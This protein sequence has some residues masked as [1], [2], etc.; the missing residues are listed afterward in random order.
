MSRGWLY[1]LTAAL[2][3]FILGGALFLNFRQGSGP[4]RRTVFG[5]DQVDMC[6]DVQAA[7]QAEKFDALDRMGRE[8][9]TL[10]DRFVG[11]R[12]KLSGFYDFTGMDGCASSFCEAR[13]VQP[14]NIRKL[15]NWLNR[16]PRNPI[17]K[18]AMALNWYFYAWASRSCAD[19]ADIS[20]DQWQGYF[21]RL[22]IARSYLSNIDPRES[23]QYYVLMIEILCESGGPRERLDALYQ[24][25]HSAFPDFYDLTAIYGWSL[26]RSWFGSA[27]DVAWLADT[28]LTDPGGDSGQVS[29]SFIAAQAA[30]VLSTQRYFPETGLSWEKIKRAFATRKQLYGLNVHDWNAYAYIAYAAGDREVAREAYAQFGDNWDPTV[31]EDQSFYFNK[32]LPW[33]KGQ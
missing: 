30:R 28:L 25:G 3:I 2:C 6:R 32:V 27:G 29:Y 7:L 1:G 10:K 24:E 16:E 26:D 8:L 9:A 17:A 33:I 18:T 5:A 21:D 15:Q 14:E 11:G 19:F 31:W 23:P 13:P 22:R 12:E 20:F 4:D